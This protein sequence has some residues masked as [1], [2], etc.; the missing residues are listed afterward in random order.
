M[1]KKRLMRHKF[2]G[3]R[4]CFFCQEKQEPDY[5][6]VEELRRFVSE[7]GKIIGRGRTGV[8][9]QHQKKLTVAVKRA[10]ILALVPFVV[11]V[12]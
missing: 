9:R 3:K 4:V 1:I 2:Q 7:R 10:R 5:K 12:R 8:C 6:K 11:K